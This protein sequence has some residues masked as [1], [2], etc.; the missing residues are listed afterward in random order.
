VKVKVEKLQNE[1]KVK[2]IV[3][4]TKEEYE[5]KYNVEL[6]K[7][8]AEAELPGFRKGKVPTN[9]YLKRFGEAKVI[10][11]TMDELINESYFEAI[12]AKKVKVVGYPQIDLEKAPKGGFAYSAVVAVMPEVELQEYK[13]FEVEKEEAVVTSEDI[14]K[15]INRVLS[16]SADL[17]IVED[18]A[19]EN[20]NIAVFDFC[21]R[22]DGVEFEGGKA[23]NYSLEIGSGQFIPGFEEQMVGMKPEEEKVVTVKFPENYHAA[24]LAGKDAEFTVK[25]HEIKKRVLPKLTAKFVKGL[26][27]EGVETVKAYKDMVKENLTAEKQEA[28]KNKFEDDV[29]TLLCEKNPVVIPSEMVEEQVKGRVQQLENQAA[30]YGMTADVLLKYQGIESVEQYKE[31]L[32]PGVKNSIHEELLFDAIVKAEKLKL[33]KADYDKYYAE[34]AKYQRKE[35]KEVKEKLAKDQVKDRFLL[36]KA[37]D[38]VL[39]SVVIKK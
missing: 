23:E 11:N 35:V 22:V 12:K 10:N 21:G 38:L 7:L 16:N 9:M 2:L 27:I 34:I 29:I 37:R 15:E 8:V 3:S 5:A 26:E 36:F 18:G 24:A 31:L 19:L 32:T 33:T 25:V 17:E 30:Q 14:E 28:S 13:G 4:F 39:E 20:G 1:S 6:Q